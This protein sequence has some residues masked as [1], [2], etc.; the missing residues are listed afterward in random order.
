MTCLMCAGGSAWWAEWSL[1][2]VA[3][4]GHSEVLWVV[5][6]WPTVSPSNAPI[7]QW[8]FVGLLLLSGVWSRCLCLLCGALKQAK[9]CVCVCDGCA[10]AGVQDGHGCRR[11]AFCCRLCREPWPGIVSRVGWKWAVLR[12]AG[13][14]IAEPPPVCINGTK[15][16]HLPGLASPLLL[17][18]WV[19]KLVLILA[20]TSLAPGHPHTVPLA[21]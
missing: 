2:P 14:M 20:L 21:T 18:A 16:A 10:F 17:T 4:W 3:A 9:L 7:R 12:P 11:S 5:T 6:L 8:W 15:R 19:R 1:Q 13:K